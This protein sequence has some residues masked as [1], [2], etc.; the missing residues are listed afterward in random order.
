[1]AGGRNAARLQLL[2]VLNVS[3]DAELEPTDALRYQPAEIPDALKA[4]EAARELRPALKAQDQRQLAAKLSYESL[5]SE[6]LPTVN[7]FGDYGVLGRAGEVTIPT[8]TA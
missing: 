6:R 5:R 1:M 7:A 4:L 8:R 2:R 3:L